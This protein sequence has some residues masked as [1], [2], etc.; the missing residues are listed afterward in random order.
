MRS[1][2]K[3][4]AAL[5]TAFELGGSLVIFIFILSAAGV[6]ARPALA[7]ENGSAKPGNLRTA[8]RAGLTLDALDGLTSALVRLV[9]MAR[10]VLEIPIL[11]ILIPKLGIGN[12]RNAC[13][14]YS[15]HVCP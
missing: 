10:F 7:A 8:T 12:L 4:T 6:L 1:N 13:S 11:G 3:Q 15:R 9:A 14:Y 2:L 5:R